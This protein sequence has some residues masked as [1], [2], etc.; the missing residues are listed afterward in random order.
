[1]AA[2]RLVFDVHFG[3]DATPHR[4]GAHERAPNEQG[5]AH[6]GIRPTSAL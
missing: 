1:M 2:P 5:I 6:G 3:F 4:S